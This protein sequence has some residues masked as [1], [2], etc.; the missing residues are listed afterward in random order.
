MVFA[1]QELFVF[2]IVSKPAQQSLAGIVTHPRV[3]QAHRQGHEGREV[4]RVE[5]QTSER[6]RG[7][8]EVACGNLSSLDKSA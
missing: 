1:L 6:R 8:A 5:L 2:R 7:A 3:S 4:V